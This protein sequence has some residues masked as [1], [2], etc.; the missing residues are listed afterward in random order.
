MTKSEFISYI[1]NLLPSID[2]T[3][4][5]HD[6]VLAMA[7]D[8]AIEQVFSEIYKVDPHNLDI[9]VKKYV[10]DALT[11]DAYLVD[12][13]MYIDLPASVMN[14]PSKGRGVYRIQSRE[15]AAVKF[16][17]VTWYEV[18][19]V[20]SSELQYVTSKVWYTVE[21]TRIIFHNIPNGNST[22]A[23]AVWMIPKFYDLASTD[24][25]NM[26]MGQD[27][28]VIEAVITNL[29]LVKPKDLL[30]NNSDIQ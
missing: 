29:G 30:N 27:Q 1:K 2:K 23:L 25:F 8:T 10:V 9:Y 21:T 4:K 14:L 3:A 12:G 6:N 24:D 13:A 17:P 22:D 19:Q 11:T 5:Y 28:K 7:I 15:D 16:I 26:P 18:D 20:L